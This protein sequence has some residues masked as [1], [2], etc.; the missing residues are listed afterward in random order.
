MRLFQNA[1][2]YN[3]RIALI[4]NGESFSYDELL[5]TSYRI[6]KNILGS[7]NDLDEARITFL[8]EPSFDYTAVLYGIWMAGGI[9]VPLCVQHPLASMKYV[10]EDAQAEMVISDKKYEFMAKELADKSGIPFLS[11]DFL[12]QV[13]D[14]T[15]PKIDPDRRAMIIYTSGTTNKPKGVVTTHRHIQAQITTL[16]SAWEWTEE[17]RILNV[18]PLHHVHG[19]VNVMLCALWSGACCEFLPKFDA[20]DVWLKLSSGELT[21]FMGVPTM[22]F[23]LITK[24]EDSSPQSQR[25]FSEEVSKLR[26]MVSGSAALPVSVLEK[27][28][29]ITG[30][31]LLERYGMTEIGMGLSNSYRGERRAGHVGLP[32]PGVELKLVDSEYNELSNGIPGEILI[33]GPSVFEEYWNKP[34]AT[35]EAFTEDGWFKTGDMAVFNEGSYKI[36][37]RNSVDIIK[38]GGYKISALE[39]EDVLRK[40]PEINDCAVVGIPDEEWGEVVAAGIISTGDSID[41]ENLTHWIKEYLPTYKIPRKYTFLKALPRNVLGKVVKT[42]VKDLFS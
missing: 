30:H 14:R 28:R 10:V 26:L 35:Q 9:A 40:H 15:L 17:D 23:K 37:G 4:S 24:W 31:T 13:L 12:N 6:A 34:D 25:L 42:K 21:L 1:V 32:L 41:V 22:Y 33:K 27:W 20:G 36:L 19:I 16:V 38:S 11:V 39:I 18:L 8:I 2:T 3:S 7:R 29:E 5:K